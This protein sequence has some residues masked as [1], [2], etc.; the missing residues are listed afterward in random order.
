MRI[1]SCGALFPMIPG[2]PAGPVVPGAA[3]HVHFTVKD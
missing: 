3:G 1:E 2:N